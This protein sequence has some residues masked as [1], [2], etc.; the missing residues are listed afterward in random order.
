VAAP[1]R[2]KT[3]PTARPATDPRQALLRASRTLDRER[4]TLAVRQQRLLR[5]FRAWEKQVRLVARLEKRVSRL[6]ADAPPG[7]IAHD[8]QP[9]GG[10]TVSAPHAPEGKHAP[11]LPEALRVAEAAVNRLLEECQK[12]G[13]L[14]TR[15]PKAV[16]QVSRNAKWLLN[17]LD[18]LRRGLA[19]D[20]GVAGP[21]A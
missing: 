9:Q 5:C 7:A 16:A 12:G 21:T 17:A 10:P 2:S 20:A 1:R 8:P 4:A 15:S 6:A 13:T 18:A 3:A 11:E 19:A 14:Y